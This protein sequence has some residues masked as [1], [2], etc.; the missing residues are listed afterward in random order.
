M[1]AVPDPLTQAVIITSEGLFEDWESVFVQHRWAESTPIFRF[2]AVERDPIPALWDKLQF[3]PGVWV[4]ITLGG[5]IALQNG[6]IVTRQVSY[7]ANQ[8][9]VELIG[10]SLTYFAMKSSVDVPDGNFDGLNF[11]QIA[12]KVLAKYQGIGIKVIGELDSSVF[13]N[14][15]AE[16]GEVNWDFLEKLARFRGIVLGSDHLSN[17]LLIGDHLNPVTGNLVEGVNILSCQ[18]VISIENLSAIYQMVNSSMGTD[19]QNGTDASEQEAETGGTGPPTSN[20]K[21]PSVVPV[22]D[23]AELQK[24]VY[25]EAGWS[26]GTAVQATI[27]TPGWMAP[28]TTNLWRAGDI[29]TV[30][31]PM[32]ILNQPMA[33]RTVTFTQDGRGTLTTLDLVIPWLLRDL[34]PPGVN[35]PARPSAASQTPAPE[36]ATPAPASTSEPPPQQ[37]AAPVP[38]SFR[39]PYAFR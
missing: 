26:E 9:G 10:K 39:W 13:Q 31:S 28:G 23:P 35:F 29:V 37:P 33:I 34:I 17:V 5:Q 2:T 30:V 18:C 24:A 11:E 7:D 14:L 19:G 1:L 4:N 20:I 21:T 32:A 27:T 6:I 16:P 25:N 15:Q 12:R 22:F 36:K 3:K 38:Q 8:H